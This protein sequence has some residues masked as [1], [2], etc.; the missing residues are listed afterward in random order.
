MKRQTHVF[1]YFITDDKTHETCFVY[2]T[3]DDKTYN[4]WFVYF[5][6]NT[7]TNTVIYHEFDDFYL[8]YNTIKIIYYRNAVVV[9]CLHYHH[10]PGKG[11]LSW[12]GRGN[13]SCPGKKTYDSWIVYFT[14][15]AAIAAVVSS[16]I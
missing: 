4:P 3:P 1:V 6:I 2:L 9:Y 13:I 14:A 8:N 10:L 5:I 15:A 7:N 16:Y 12:P 11:N